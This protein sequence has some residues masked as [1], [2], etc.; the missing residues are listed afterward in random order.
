LQIIS[1]GINIFDIDAKGQVVCA[2]AASMYNGGFTPI[3]IFG[4]DKD[5]FHLIKT[6]SGQF[7]YYCISANSSEGYAYEA[8][9]SF[10]QGDLLSMEELAFVEEEANPALSD[11]KSYRYRIDGK[12]TSEDAYV[13]KVNAFLDNAEE[14]PTNVSAVMLTDKDDTSDL[15]A[16]LEL[17]KEAAANY[18]PLEN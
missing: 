17:F 1:G 4:S 6:E 9:I 13:R 16:A 7:S 12:E 14:L 5:M 11:E 15:Q 10:A 2:S 18:K 3:S 8:Y